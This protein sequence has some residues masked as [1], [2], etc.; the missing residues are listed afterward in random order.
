MSART[1][2]HSLLNAYFG[3]LLSTE[4]ARQ[5]FIQREKVFWVHERGRHSLSNMNGEIHK[6]G[7]KETGRGGAFRKDIITDQKRKRQHLPVCAN[8]L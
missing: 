2:A 8:S 7:N 6:V 1:A 5:A 3:C 4:C